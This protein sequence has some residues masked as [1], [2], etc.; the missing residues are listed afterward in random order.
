MCAKLMQIHSAKLISALCARLTLCLPFA[1]CLV[2][3]FS[4]FC[5]TFSYFVRH[6]NSSFFVTVSTK[7]PTAWRVAM[8]SREGGR[9]GS[10]AAK[11]IHL[12]CV[13][14]LSEIGG[15]N[16]GGGGSGAKREAATKTVILNA[17]PA[18]LTANNAL[19]LAVQFPAIHSTNLLLK[20]SPVDVKWKR[21]VK[22]KFRK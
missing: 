10:P 5:K 17:V 16:G 18:L 15:G 4:K 3:F 9:D 6:R 11:C 8:T 13:K 22:R 1:V 2:N 19:G 21:K 12:E 20:K 7:S 14:P